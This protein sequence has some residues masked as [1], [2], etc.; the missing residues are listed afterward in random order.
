MVAPGEAK[1]V[2]IAANPK[3]GAGPG[4]ALVDELGRQLSDRKLESEVVYD[5]DKLKLRAAELEAKSQLQ[6]VVS[7]GGDGTVSAIANRIEPSVPISIFPLGTENLLALHLGLTADPVAAADSVLANQQVTM[8]VGSAGG[9]LFLVM[10][11]VGFDALVVQDMTKRRRGHINRFSYGGPIVRSMVGYRFPMLHFAA[12]E[13][14]ATATAERG[15]SD[16]SAGISS[17]KVT[18]EIPPAAW[19]FIFNVPRY[20]AGLDFCPSADPHD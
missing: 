2:L 6:C 5:L 19:A 16:A 1:R 7:A 9:K 20:A 15:S 4:S 3:S 11:S 14:H 8:D 17:P 18:P 13:P 10:L 12:G